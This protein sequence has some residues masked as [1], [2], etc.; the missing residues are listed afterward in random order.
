HAIGR[1][2]HHQAVLLLDRGL[3][4]LRHLPLNQDTLGQRID[5]LAVGMNALIPLGEQDRLVRDL[6]EAEKLCAAVG[7]PKRTCSI[8]CQLTNALWMMGKHNEAL[9]AARQAV[10]L[11]SELNY[12]RLQIASQYN[13]AMEYH[14]LAR[15]EDTISITENILKALAGE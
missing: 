14:A 3:D 6:R 1:S 8:L 15:Y 13:L 12:T 5:F 7:E 11:A 2:S 9:A 10:A 4:A